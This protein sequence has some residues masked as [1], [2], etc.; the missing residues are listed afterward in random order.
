MEELAWTEKKKAQL[1]EKLPV[2]MRLSGDEINRLARHVQIK[3]YN[4]SETIYEEAGKDEF[5][6]FIVKG[7]V[8]AFKYNK[9]GELVF[10]AE[11][12]KKGII[13][14]AILDNLPYAIRAV[15][16]T[17]TWLLT[18]S[19]E[20]FKFIEEKDLDLAMHL[21]RSFSQMLLNF[22]RYVSAFMVDEKSLIKTK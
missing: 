22:M 21:Y 1:M 10:I 4:A 9:D 2:F 20:T 15:A 12:R 6:G 13:G 14:L 19:K 11:S 7:R 3:K 17:D 8:H 16:K 18:L 5:M